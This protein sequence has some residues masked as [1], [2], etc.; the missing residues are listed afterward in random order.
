MYPHPARA[1]PASALSPGADRFGGDGL[2]R[3]FPPRHQEPV[4]CLVQRE[5]GAL[6]LFRRAPGHRQRDVGAPVLD[7]AAALAAHRGAGESLPCELFEGRRLHAGQGGGRRRRP[8]FVQRRL[9]GPLAQRAHVREAHAVGAEHAGQRVEQDARH[10]QRVGDQAGVLAG[11]AAEAAQHV[12]GDVVPALRGDAL[13][14]AGH[15]LAGHADEVVGELLGSRWLDAGGA[16]ARGHGRERPARRLLVERPGA[17]RTEHL[18]E[19]LRPQFA[20]DQIAVGHG[21]RPALAVARRPGVGAG[22]PRP[23]PVPPVLERADRA[24][25]G[26]HRVHAQ[27]RRSQPHAAH[28]ALVAPLQLTGEVA[29]VGRR[30]AHVEPD[31]LVETRALAHRHRPDHAS[32]RAGEDGVLAAEQRRVGQSAVRLH[33]PQP[34][35]AQLRR[36]AVDVVPQD[37]GEVGVDHRGLAA[38]HQLHQRARLV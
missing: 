11:R 32:R 12:A 27:H 5:E 9:H 23:D 6:H 21:E 20:G 29:H 37:G 18:R 25:A 13:D 3:E 35:V 8:R 33:E 17:V 34:H 4:P 15:G 22:A 26:R 28:H 7:V 30:A 16:H 38:A 31:D 24:S 36:H 2:E 10:A 14:R 1:P 19:E